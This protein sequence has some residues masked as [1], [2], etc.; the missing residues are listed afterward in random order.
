MQFSIVFC[1]IL[2]M[3][4]NNLPVCIQY[5]RNRNMRVGLVKSQALNGTRQLMGSWEPSLVVNGFLKPGTIF[6]RSWKAMTLMSLWQENKTNKIHCLSIVSFKLCLDQRWR[7]GKKG[8]RKAENGPPYGVP[9]SLQYFIWP[10]VREGSN[11][12]MKFVAGGESAQ[13]LAPIPSL[14]SSSLTS[15]LQAVGRGLLYSKW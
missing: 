3:P 1:I 13:H 7:K 9:L 8:K 6:W 4:G 15:V 11:C 5:Y 2:L 12:E 14:H 10:T